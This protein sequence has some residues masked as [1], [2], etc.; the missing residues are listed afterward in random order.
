MWSLRFLLLLACHS[1]PTVMNSSPLEAC[2]YINSFLCRLYLMMSFT[3]YHSSSR[4]ANRRWDQE[5][6][7]AALKRTDHVLCGECGRL[8]NFKLK[9]WLNAEKKVLI[10]CP[11]GSLE[12]KSAEGNADSEGPAHKVS[13]RMRTLSL[14][15]RPFVWCLSKEFGYFLDMSWELYVKMN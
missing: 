8:W 3:S 11:S 10:G 2:A 1:F 12:D 4:V 9:M 6:E 7:N 5:S 14:C 15:L 13:G